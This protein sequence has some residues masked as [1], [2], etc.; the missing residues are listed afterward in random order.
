MSAQNTVESTVDMILAQIKG[1]IGTYLAEV[2]ADRSGPGMGAVTTEDPVAYF[3]YEGAIGYKT[4]AIFVIADSVDYHK[5]RGQNHINAT[6]NM[7]VSVVVEDRLAHLIT[8]KLYRYQDAVHKCLD[9]QELVDTTRLIK[10]VLKVVRTDFGSTQTKKMSGSSE[11][12]FRKEVMLT[13]QVEH[14]EKEN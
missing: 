14:Y 11:V 1:N 2:R 8:T 12:T 13:L 5:E 6:I 9:R 3:I 4:P 7:F 10:N